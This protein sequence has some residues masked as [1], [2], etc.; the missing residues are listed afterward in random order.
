VTNNKKYKDFESAL[1]RL[2]E[3]TAALESGDVALEE[4]MALYA[5]G[6]E[7]AGFCSRK[8]SE[9]EKK[10]AIL[11]EINGTLQ[12]TPFENGGDENGEKET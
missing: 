9:A 1:Q 6:V 12:E 8:L 4:S 2:E 11:K 5:E 10:I 3:I 7:I